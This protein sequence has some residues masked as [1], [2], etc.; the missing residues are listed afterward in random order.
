M[1]SISFNELHIE[2]LTKRHNLNNFS[3][4]ERDLNDFLKNDAFNDQEELTSRTFVCIYNN[5]VVGFFS[6]LADAI[7]VQ[8][9]QTDDNVDG[10]CYRKYPA[11]KIGR[12]ATDKEYERKGVGTYLYL[13]IC[14][15]SFKILGIMGIRFITVDS[16]NESIEF[17]QKMGFT[18][19]NVKKDYPTLYKDIHPIYLKLQGQD[20]KLDEYKNNN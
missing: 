15:A 12:L 13:N 7:R 9:I 1:A 5:K 20:R 4:T 10:Y 3:C 11:M 2:P 17:Y 14:G 16:K 8:D 18:K 19:T 6:L